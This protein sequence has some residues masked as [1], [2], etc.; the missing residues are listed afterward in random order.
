MIEATVV[1]NGIEGLEE[2]FPSR[3]NVRYRFVE[4]DDAPQ[5]DLDD[6]DLLIVPN[7]SDHVAMLTLRHQVAAFLDRGGAV[8]CFDGW[9]TDWL[10][11]NRWVHDNSRATRDVRYRVRTDRHALFDGVDLD[12][13]QFTHGISGWWACGRIEPAPG[14]DVVLED[15]WGRP[16]IVLDE[17]TTPGLIA[18]TASGPLGSAAGEGMARG[19][20][21]VY[22]RLIDVVSKRPKAAK[23][24]ADVVTDR[25]MVHGTRG[26]IGLLF[27]GVW[28]QWAFA[29][30]PKYRD[31]YE[32]I[33][34]HHLDYERIR[35]LDA[36]IVPFQSHQA[37][38]SRRADAIYRFLADGK[39]VA[40]FGDS[41]VAWI[42]ATWEWRPV[43]NYWW[44]E[45]P[46]SPP[47]SHTDFAHPVYQGL[48]QRHACWHIHGIYTDIPS[49]AITVQTNDAGETITWQTHAHG[50]TLF[51]STLDPIVEHGIQ[52]IR[53]LDHYCDKLT[54]W[55]CGET[56][57]GAFSIP[58]D[59]YGV[60]HVAIG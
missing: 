40:V 36:L 8:F 16:M 20:E 43:N 3:A 1:S 54:T 9:F 50:G 15:T 49:N 44:V 38:I 10:P 5:L 53:H 59:A 26:K 34:V 14:A 33:Y 56:P 48:S 17:V 25:A 19:L 13:F 6:T 60:E 12:D 4:L 45:D 21:Q 28:S 22:R 11:G 52:Q 31:L 27:N 51:A 46:S 7:G 37:A 39:K 35:H 2:F 57:V 47:I 41:D 30:A 24:V 55:L 42:D 18:L 32:L 23:P 58:D 29:T